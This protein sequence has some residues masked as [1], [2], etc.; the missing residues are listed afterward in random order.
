VRAFYDAHLYPPPITDLA[1]HREL[2]R[3]TERRRAMFHLLWPGRPQRPNRDI[4][5]AGCGTSQAVTYAL[6]EPDARVIGIDISETGLSFPRAAQKNTVSKI[7][8]SA[9]SRSGAC[10]NW[11]QIRSDRRHGRAPSPVQPRHR[12]AAA[13]RRPPAGWG[14]VRKPDALAA[15]LLHP[16]ER[17]YTVPRLYEWLERAGMALG[18]GSSRHPI[19]RD[20]G[21]RRACRMPYLLDPFPRSSLRAQCLAELHPAAPAMDPV[22]PRQGASRFRGCPHQSGAYLCRPRPSP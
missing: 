12:S 11:T 7:S 2:Y 8:S 22:H 17:A 18:A 16:H 5:I 15:A 4:P 21:P 14:D 1:P 20:E 10:G 9:S 3:N 6:S 13:A 19:R